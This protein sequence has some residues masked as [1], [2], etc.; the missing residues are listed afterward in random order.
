[1]PIKEKWRNTGPGKGDVSDSLYSNSVYVAASFSALGGDQNRR[2]M[3]PI[4]S[5]P[6]DPKKTVHWWGRSHTERRIKTAPA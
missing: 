3:G 1:M 5:H 2:A 4:F 6:E